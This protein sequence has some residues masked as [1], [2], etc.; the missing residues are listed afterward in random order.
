MAFMRI[1][2]TPCG[3]HFQMDLNIDDDNVYVTHLETGKVVMVFTWDC[4]IQHPVTKQYIGC[5]C[6]KKDGCWTIHLKDGYDRPY[7][8]EGTQTGCSDIYDAEVIAVKMLFDR[9]VLT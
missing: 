7:S 6:M 5:M 1:V 4:C 9:G 8:E 2:S 3:N